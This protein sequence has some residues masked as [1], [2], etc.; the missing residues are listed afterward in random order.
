MSNYAKTNRV[1]Y[2]KP[3]KQQPGKKEILLQLH[4]KC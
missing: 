4:M 1:I 2:Q 3:L